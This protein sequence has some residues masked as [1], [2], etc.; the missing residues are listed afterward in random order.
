[1]QARIT[2]RDGVKE[3]D[4]TDEVEG[5]RTPAER[6]EAGVIDDRL[7]VGIRE[8]FF[9]ACTLNSGGASSGGGV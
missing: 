3:S 8:G 6:V 1:M 7:E 2:R 4:H 5:D 9:D